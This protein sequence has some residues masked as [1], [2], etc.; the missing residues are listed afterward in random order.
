MTPTDFAA[1]ELELWAQALSEQRL[2][3]EELEAARRRR[4]NEL[5]IE[6]IPQLHELRT[7]ADLLLAE[8]VKVKCA[9]RHRSAKS[10]WVSTTVPGVVPGGSSP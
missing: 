5:V 7:R 6:L 8:A 1:V 4:R 10:G 9:F 2:A 3:E